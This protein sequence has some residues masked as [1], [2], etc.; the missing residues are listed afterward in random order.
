MANKKADE[1]FNW[2]KSSGAPNNFTNKDLQC[3]KCESETESL[4]SCEQ[5]PDMKPG[6][7]LYGGTCDKFKQ[8]QF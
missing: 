3:D 1:N 7:V 5:F 6:K 2:G 8:K 4:I